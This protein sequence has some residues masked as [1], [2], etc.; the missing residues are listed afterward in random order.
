M[1]D[2]F[3]SVERSARHEHVSGFASSRA[4]RDAPRARDVLSLIF[5]A[6]IVALIT[7]EDKV[8]VLLF[9]FIATFITIVVW[10]ASRPGKRAFQGRIPV[11]ETHAVPA[12]LRRLTTN[13]AARCVDHP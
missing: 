4:C 12:Q 3:V 11:R 1:E 6:G 5:V 2:G 10:Y 8:A 7:T 13:R 9:V